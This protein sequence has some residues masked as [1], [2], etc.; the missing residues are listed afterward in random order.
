MTPKQE[1]FCLAFIETGNASD[2]Y[3]RAY[4][5]GKMKPAT[6][7]YCFI[8]NALNHI[9]R[10]VHHRGHRQQMRLASGRIRLVFYRPGRVCNWVQGHSDN[11]GQ[12]FICGAIDR[13]HMA[14]LGRKDNG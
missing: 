9:M 2:A 6:I 10:P 1:A 14:S 7:N 8:Y 5:A 13:R 12:R 3:R 11:T 4:S